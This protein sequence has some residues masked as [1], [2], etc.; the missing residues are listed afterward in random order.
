M[1]L[2]F[3]SLPFLLCQMPV[4]LREKASTL[5]MSWAYNGVHVTNQVVPFWEVAAFFNPANLLLSNS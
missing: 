3:L 4:P 2:P 1:E 5:R